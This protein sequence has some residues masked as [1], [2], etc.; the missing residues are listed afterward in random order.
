MMSFMAL[1]LGSVYAAPDFSSMTAVSDNVTTTLATTGDTITFTL[2]LTASDDANGTGVVTFDVGASTGLTATFPLVGSSTT[3]SATYTVLGGQNGTVSVTNI[4]FQ[5]GLNED[6]TNPPLFPYTPTPSNVTVD[7]TSPV[8]AEVTPVSTLTNDNTP[9]YTFSSDEA[10][11]ISYGGDCSS[12][13]TAASSGNNTVTFNTL[14]DGPHTNCTVIV[15]DATGNSSSTLNVTGFSVDTQAPSLDSVSIATNGNPGFAREGQSVTFTVNFDESA[16]VSAINT[17]SSATN[18]TTLT[19]EMDATAS[20]S[21]QL[22]FTVVDGDNGSVVPTVNFD[23][24]DA[25]GNTATITSLG[26]ITGGP[27][28]TDTVDP[29]LNPVSIASNN[30][31]PAFAKTNDTVTVS[32]T[33]SETL[34]GV[35]GTL[36]TEAGVAANPSGDNWTL[37]L[38]TDGNETEGLTPF[39]ID[40]QDQAGNTG[41]QVTG[42]TDGSSVTFDR[43][44]PTLVGG[45]VTMASTNSY[46]ADA[47]VYYA[48]VGDTLTLTFETV[49]TIQTPTGTLLGKTPA[50]VNTSG[51][52]WTASVVGDAVDP[53]GTAGIDI[54][55]LDLAG[56][57]SLNIISTM[58]GTSVFYDRTAPDSPTTVLDAQ[59]IATANFKAIADAVFNWSGEGDL[60]A[61]DLVAGSGVINF[62]V[63]F[64]NTNTAINESSTVVLPARTFTPASVIPDSDVYNFYI[65]TVDKAGNTSG[66]QLLYAQAYGTSSTGTVVDKDSGLP[67]E[68][69]YINIIS[70]FG[71]YC[72]PGREICTVVSDV[73]G[74]FSTSVAPGQEYKIDVIKVPTH[75]IAK[76]SLTIGT[77]AV[78]FNA[79][80]DLVESGKIQTGNQAVILSTS[81]TFSINGI[82][83]TSQITVNSFSGEATYTNT[84]AGIEITSFARITGL[85][86]NN[87]EAE[88]I[89]QGNNV[90][91]VKNIGNVVTKSSA[92]FSP[93]G[94]ATIA[95]SSHTG[96][97]SGMTRA[98]KALGSGRFLSYEES[99]DFIRTLNQG[100][101]G[102]TLYYTNRNGYKIFAGYIKGKVSIMVFNQY[103]RV[104]I[105]Y[106]GYRRH[107]QSYDVDQASVE[108][109][110]NA[111]NNKLNAQSKKHKSV[112]TTNR[113]ESMRRLYALKGKAMPKIIRPNRGNMVVSVQN[114]NN[115]VAAKTDKFARKS[116]LNPKPSRISREKNLKIIKNT[117]KVA[118]VLRGLRQE[119]QGSLIRYREEVARN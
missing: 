17:A 8:V 57:N 7:T 18:I 83:Q 54:H 72:Q 12:V 21:D 41:T 56:N 84:G 61:L 90:Y 97:F 40:F 71:E 85:S 64:E 23:L 42:V 70:K 75:Y 51:N 98:E 11:T 10:G 14:P 6:L 63:R 80:L 60:D 24:T 79:Q 112:A 91:L 16:T 113:Y 35:S 65:N 3:H 9:D 30:I 55:I 45:S 67:I 1:G 2:T 115:Y 59:G 43:T 69:A 117:S 62:Q 119:S 95:G 52:V 26:A 114:R 103:S 81:K 89:G 33:G 100:R 88:I 66:E 118:S 108:K 102:Q 36:F 101:E 99:M 15:T 37:S 22:I 86:S 29:T 74:E 34:T 82:R 58:D 104:P 31:N 19:Q 107:R 106:R 25:A 38:L 116:Y 20:T 77:S 13:T 49:E 46:I 105:V 92:L 93:V 5:N 87:P 48:R 109:N 28:L 94:I 78:V 32:F 53:E 110:Y 39:T 27:I 44:N 73:N 68:G 50:F 47:P 111:I 96:G 4:T 76:E